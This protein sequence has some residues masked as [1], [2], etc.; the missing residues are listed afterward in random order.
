MSIKNSQ[1]TISTPSGTTLLQKSIQ[2]AETKL[3]GAIVRQHT[4]SIAN[5]VM[6]L[7]GIRDELWT[8]FMDL[9]VSE[10]QVLCSKEPSSLFRQMPVK[11]I[12]QFQ[13]EPLVKELQSKAPLLLKLLYAVVVRQDR[14]CRVK[15]QT[16]HYP[17]I[18]TATAILLKE[19]N[20][21]MG[22]VQ[23]IVSC[24]M[25]ACHSEKQVLIRSR[26]QSSNIIDP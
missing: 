3:V 19:R 2:H 1:T 24:L 26:S 22:G 10:F 9:I 8:F 23:S 7:P 16:V 21:E 4:P 14:R 20:R 12:D 13:W 17:A 25:Y 18:V 11:E 15:P 6:D 5:A